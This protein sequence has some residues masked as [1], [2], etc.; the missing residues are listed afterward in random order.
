MKKH[1]ILMTSKNQFRFLHG[2]RLMNIGSLLV[3]LFKAHIDFGA[4]NKG[5]K[6]T[7]L[8]DG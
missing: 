8:H 7:V 6:R 1:I 4:S 3:F 5:A 2:G